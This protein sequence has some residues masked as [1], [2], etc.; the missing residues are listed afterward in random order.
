MTVHIVWHPSCLQHD[1]GKGHP[2]SPAR[3]HAI[4]H[5]LHTMQNVELGWSE[6]A[7]ASAASLRAVH[8]Q[9]HL[10][11]L[12]ELDA[13]GG[14]QLDPDTIMS[15][16]S[17]DAAVHA[18]G[19]AE[20][21]AL[22]VLDGQ[23]AFAAIRPPGHHATSDTPMGFCLLN[24]V[25]V[26]AFAALRQ[27]G[28]SRVLIIDWD[29]H[30]GNGTQDIVEREPRIRYVSLHQWPL[31]PGTG[32]AEERGADNIFNLP[33]PPGLPRHRYLGDLNVAVAAATTDW[34]PDL[35]LI[36]AGF[37][38]MAGDPLAGF[39]LEPRDYGTWVRG[40]RS[41]GAPIGAVLEGGYV[42]DRISIAA[43]EMVRALS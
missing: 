20:E 5:E 37:D 32:R 39:T 2:E 27:P 3:L 41:I 6:S 28:V 17:L 19:A 34:T 40:W 10:D 38:A 43:A 23:A 33:R 31:Y 14:G 24:N 35:I 16:A 11:R 22:R 21:V 30:H 29:V 4:L 8:T 12:A 1:P 7:P 42:P 18:A 26:A 13:R 36:S 15:A 9:G 25:A